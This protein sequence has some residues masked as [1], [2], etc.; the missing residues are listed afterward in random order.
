VCCYQQPLRP[1]E[2]CKTHRLSRSPVES[3]IS[4]CQTCKHYPTWAEVQRTF[5]IFEYDVA[6]AEPNG[7]GRGKE[8]DPLNFLNDITHT[9]TQDKDAAYPSFV[10][11]IGCK[12]GIRFVNTRG[13]MLFAGNISKEM[14]LVVCIGNDLNEADAPC[15]AALCIVCVS[16]RCM[17]WG[18]VLHWQH[19]QHLSSHNIT[20]HVKRT[21]QPRRLLTRVHSRT[22]LLI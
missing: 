11:Q 19:Y 4:A 5:L 7:L 8:M 16:C 10:F 20:K 18:G 21:N 1:L 13:S 3:F 17:S 14:G 12:S 6:V 15:P 22:W 9:V 2:L